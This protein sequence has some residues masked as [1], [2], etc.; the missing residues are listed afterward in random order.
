MRSVAL[1]GLAARKV[2][3]LLTALAVVIGV[4]MVSGTFILT[5]TTLKSFTGLFTASTGQH[6]RR[7][8]RQGDRQELHQRQ[9]GHD[10]RVHA[11]QGPGA[12]RGR[13]G[14]RRGQ[15][16]GGQ[17]RRHH[18]LRRQE[19]RHGE[20]RRQLRRRHRGPQPVQAQDR[21]GPPW[22]R[23]G[24][25]RRRHRREEALQ[26]RRLGRRLDPRQEAHLPH[27]RHA[28]LRRRRLARLRQHR[29]LGRQDR[30]GPARPRGP[31]RRDLGRREGRHLVRAARERDQAARRQRPR[32]QG[33]QGRGQGQRRAASTTA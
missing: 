30:P 23:R 21:Q 26:G 16:A 3:A 14:R 4:A 5:D 24:R 27:Q 15:P 2:R 19:G 1:K 32:G 11:R 20:R 10:P 17:R 22:A 8:Q 13:G 9:R 18:R 12:A 25:D 7:H 6:R 31:L 29:R 28:V 33:L